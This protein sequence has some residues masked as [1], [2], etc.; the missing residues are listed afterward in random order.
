M[1]HRKARKTLAARLSGD[2][3]A[4]LAMAR[5]WVDIDPLDDDAN[6]ALVDGLVRSGRRTEALRLYDRYAERLRRELDVEPLDELRELVERVRTGDHPALQAPGSASSDPG[7][8]GGPAPE[9]G[10]EAEPAA[11]A[12][13]AIDPADGAV[14]HPTLDVIRLIGR[15]AVGSVYLAR[16]IELRRLVAV[17]VLSA[18]LATD[19]TARRRFERDAEAAAR[20]HHPNVVPVYRI[21]RTSSGAPFI[22]M[23]WVNGGSLAARL[24]AWGPFEL[25]DALRATADVAAGV[26]AAHRIHIIHRDVRPANVLYEQE[27]G[28]NLL[29]D[30]G[31]ATVVD[32][33]A[34]GWERLTRTGEWIGNPSCISPEQLLGQPVSEKTDVYGLGTLA[35]ELLAGRGPFD[36]THPAEFAVAHVRT[37]PHRLDDFATGVP[38][39]IVA[40]IHRCLAKRP[41]HRP[42]LDEV[43]SAVSS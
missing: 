16:E 30:F 27:T 33:V 25:D 9:S 41:E 13:G 10:S 11:P 29:C 17:K 38:D 37:P 28:R 35:Y 22:A 23:P 26:M 8:D 14:L 4:L 5:E 15:G 18:E 34:G 39:R 20:I 36:A 3:A 24:A 2:D 31:I 40:L 43:V 6:L 12:S 42:G 7:Q 19:P 1:L 32:E 21:G